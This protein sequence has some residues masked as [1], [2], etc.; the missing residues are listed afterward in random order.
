MSKSVLSILKCLLFEMDCLDARAWTEMCDFGG[1][2][3]MI[4]ELHSF[5]GCQ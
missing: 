3:S 2:V 4:N 5:G 1:S